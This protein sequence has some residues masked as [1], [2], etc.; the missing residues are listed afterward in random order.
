[1]RFDCWL[2]R[3]ATILAC[4]AIG[5]AA[6]YQ[7]QLPAAPGKAVFEKT[8]APCHEIKDVIARRRTKSSWLQIVEEMVARGAE[9]TE[10]DLTAVVSY[11]SSQFGKVNVNAAAVDEIQKSLGLSEKDSRAIVTYREQNG[12]IQDFEQLQ[13]APGI[14]VEKLREKRASIA[15]AQ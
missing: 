10:E 1:V 14:D 5:R 4:V 11:L 2:P 3:V 12:K 15:F 9:G 13:K 7:T 8:C 6:E